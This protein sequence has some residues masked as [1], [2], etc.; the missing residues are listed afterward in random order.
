MSLDDA[1]GRGA[2]NSVKVTD[3]TVSSRYRKVLRLSR[4]SRVER[5]HVEVWRFPMLVRVGGR[6]TCFRHD[7]M[8][9]ASTGQSR[10]VNVG[11]RT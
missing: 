10:K 8:A 1:M 4:L 3:L 11:N 7:R 9:R 2:S 6:G 5:M